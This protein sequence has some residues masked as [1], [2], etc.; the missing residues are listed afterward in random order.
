MNY[1][2]KTNNLSEILETSHE[3]PIIIFKYSS[4]CNSSAR[5]K[6]DFKKRIFEKTLLAPVYIVV[7]Q[8]QPSLSKNIA[9]AL[10]VKHESPQILIINK[11][12]LFYT[13]HHS[14]IN[15]ENLSS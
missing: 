13:A 15:L 6:K 2:K 1:F 7:V 14:G 4:Q 8:E 10:E 5:L 11:G 3:N 12:K 9:K